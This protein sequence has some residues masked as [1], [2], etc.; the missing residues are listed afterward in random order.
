MRLYSVRF[1]FFILIAFASRGSLD[2]QTLQIDRLKANYLVNFAD[3]VRWNG[4]AKTDRI[5]IGILNDED[6][7][8]ELKKISHETHGERLLNIIELDGSENAQL[9]NIDILFVGMGRDNAWKSLKERCQGKNILLVGEDRDF[10][11]D[12]GAIQFTFRKN[13]LRFYV[14]QKNATALGIQLSAKLVELA[15]EQSR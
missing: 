12:G 6:L 15:A 8:W 1:L 3:F 5:T 2:G 11:N 14:D 10:L 7:S 4:Q 13:R 9:E